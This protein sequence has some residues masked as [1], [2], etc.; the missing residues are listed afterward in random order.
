MVSCY[1]A[2]MLS[3]HSCFL[4][5]DYGHQT[6]K[7]NYSFTTGFHSLWT[8]VWFLIFERLL[9]RSATTDQS[10][11]WAV[12]SLLA[13][14]CLEDKRVVQYFVYII[15][16]IQNDVKITVW[17]VCSPLQRDI[18]K[19]PA[20]RRQGRLASLTNYVFK[21]LDDSDTYINQVFS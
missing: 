6:Y 15:A 16:C 17:P 5:H 1:T 20:F 8:N 3:C 18:W 7:C 11:W 4:F 13:K 19:N 12:L 10:L 2:Y 9:T 14:H 21:D